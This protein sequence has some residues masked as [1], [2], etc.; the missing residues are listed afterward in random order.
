[1]KLSH[2]LLMVFG[3]SGLSFFFSWLLSFAGAHLSSTERYWLSFTIAFFV[4]IILAWPVSRLFRLS[5]LMIF[6][7]PCPGCHTRP[8][9]WWATEAGKMRLILNCGACGEQSELWLTRR[10]TNDVSSGTGHIFRLRWPE[11]LGIWR[12]VRS[13]HTTGRDASA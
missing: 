5:P 6:A 1:M 13:Q 2:L 10:P 11:F 9:G 7:G 8:P 4:A 3:S 12:E